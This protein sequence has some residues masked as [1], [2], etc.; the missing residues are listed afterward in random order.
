[1]RV[2]V[3]PRT[4]TVPAGE[5]VTLLVTVVNTEQIISAHRVS[6]LGVDPAWVELDREQLSLF[7]DAAEVVTATVHL[8]AGIPAGVRRLAVQVREITAPGDVEVVEVEVVVPAAHGARVELE[9]PTTTGGSRAEI[10]VVLTNDGNAEAELVLDGTD[11]D[12]ALRFSFDP[13]AVRLAPGERATAVATAR[14]RRPLTGSPRIR[15]LTVLARRAGGEPASTIGTFVQK[16]VVSRAGLGLLGL[17]AAISVFAA[18]IATTFGQ[19]VDHRP[20]GGVVRTDAMQEHQRRTIR[21]VFGNR[22][23]GISC[24][25]VGRRG[26]CTGLVKHAWQLRLSV[27]LRVRTAHY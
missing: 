13:P 5:A 4:A 11:A 2:E 9:P 21:G 15:Q 18:V 25:D 3:T 23:R 19:V 8:P 24:I 26:W 20:P 7:P 6:V 10:G 12:Q 27:V 17:L 14:G 1:M 16:P 22:Q